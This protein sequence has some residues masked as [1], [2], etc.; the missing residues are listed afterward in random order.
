MVRR[1]SAFLYL[2]KLATSLGDYEAAQAASGRF[3]KTFSASTVSVSPE[4]SNKDPQ[5]RQRE[6]AVEEAHYDKL[7]ADVERIRQLVKR[8][9]QGEDTQAKELGDKAFWN[10]N[11]S[12]AASH[13]STALSL[14]AAYL[15]CFSNRAACNLALKDYNATLVDCFH[16]LALL[17]EADE[18]A[19]EDEDDD[20][21]KAA[22]RRKI[23]ARVLSRRGAS[24]CWLGQYNASRDDYKMATELDPQNNSLRRYLVIV[25]FFDV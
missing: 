8:R 12:T 1:G 16:A 18:N 5:D 4:E 13:Y 11:Y 10:K 21:Q 20:Q 25:G 22:Q 7:C 15:A 14:D 6:A 23:R 17:D 19:G 9:A 3:S 24:Y 2:G